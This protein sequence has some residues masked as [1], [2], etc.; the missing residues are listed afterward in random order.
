VASHDLQ[1]PLR[2]VSIFTQMLSQRYGDSLDEN[3]REYIKFAVDGANRMYNLINGLLAYS[4]IQTKGKEFHEVDINNVLDE[5]LRNLSLQ[6]EKVKAVIS[7]S[8]LPVLYADR[9]QMIQL[10][11]NL[12]SNSLKFSN[13][14]PEIKISSIERD[15]YYLFSLKDKGI[16]IDPQYFERIFQ[17]FQRLLPR[18]EYEGTGIGLSIC[19]RIVERHGGK[20]WVKSQ[21]GKGATFWFTIKKG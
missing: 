21:P 19:K 17:I 4:R 15:D 11:Q 3:A 18:E 1:E 13:G 12:I 9:N 7:V 20:I 14:I 5:V 16:G 2:M 10:F 6:I 8:D